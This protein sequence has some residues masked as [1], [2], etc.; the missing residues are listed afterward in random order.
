MNAKIFTSRT[1]AIFF[2]CEETFLLF[3]VVIQAY[4][5]LGISVVNKQILFFQEPILV[6]N[7]LWFLATILFFVTIYLGISKRDPLIMKVHKELASLLFSTAKKKFLESN[8]RVA[9]LVFAELIFTLALAISIYLY[10]DPEVNIF[11]YPTNII[12]FIGVIIFGYAIFSNTRDYREETYGR[13]LIQSIFVKDYG[14]HR[15]KRITN[16]KTGS[17]RIKAKNKK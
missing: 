17:I 15:I 12:V 1:R 6:Q 8:R 3:L 5:L 16:V 11:P 7:W 2:I 14:P 10:L 9:A 4:L 13:G